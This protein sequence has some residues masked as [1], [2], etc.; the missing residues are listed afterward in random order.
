LSKKCPDKLSLRGAWR[1][2][3]LLDSLR[4]CFA[5]LAMTFE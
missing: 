4:D 1:R 2:S 3:N 5:P